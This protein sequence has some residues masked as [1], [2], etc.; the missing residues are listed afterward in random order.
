MT[1]RELALA[2]AR[3][4]VADIKAERLDKPAAPKVAV[5][6]VNAVRRLPKAS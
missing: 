4:L 1:D 6:K 3:L 5:V 2:F